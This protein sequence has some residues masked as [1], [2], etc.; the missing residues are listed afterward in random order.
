M[1][2]ISL[3]SGGLWASSVR[4]YTTV[5]LTVRTTNIVVS[6]S[7]NS[8]EDSNVPRGGERMAVSDW[9]SELVKRKIIG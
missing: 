4:I 6:Y 9:Q 1:V 3:I 8:P 2:A 7:L 5:Y